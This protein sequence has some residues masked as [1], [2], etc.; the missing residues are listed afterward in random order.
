MKKFAFQCSV[1]LPFFLTSF[2]LLLPNVRADTSFTITDSQL[3]FLNDLDSLKSIAIA[4]S[5]YNDKGPYYLILKKD[6]NYIVNFRSSYSSSDICFNR[7]NILFQTKRMYYFYSSDLSHIYQG[8]YLSEENPFSS[9][10]VYI[11]SNFPL[12]ICVNGSSTFTFNNGNNTFSISYPTDSVFPS[13]YDLNSIWNSSPSS[14]NTPILTN[15]YSVAGSKIGWLGEQIVSN[16][17]Y[18]SIIGVF[19]L[20]FLIEFIRRYFL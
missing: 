6:N 20:I 4:S 17:I 2:F 12:S 14:D 13:L 18:L 5:E 1:F 9:S 16:Y 8:G 7:Y 10:F 15:F 11:Y 3:S 19:I